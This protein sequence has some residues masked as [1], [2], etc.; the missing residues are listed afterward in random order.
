[1]FYKT[2]KDY[3]P[4]GICHWFIGGKLEILRKR[5][6]KT[7][8]NWIKLYANKY[9]HVLNLSIYNPFLNQEQ[10]NALFAQIFKGQPKPF[11]I[12]ILPFTVTLS[13]YNETLNNADIVIDGGGSEGWS[14]PSFTA[15]ALGKHAIVHNN[16]GIKEW[17]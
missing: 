17:A 11:N 15:V 16:S 14:L 8:Q 4:Q 13:E 2:G 12:N 3:H 1:H 5:H 6:L 7:I 10:H 9:D